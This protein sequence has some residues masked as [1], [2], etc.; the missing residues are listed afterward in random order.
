VRFSV[1]EGDNAQVSKNTLI[2]EF[3]IWNLPESIERHDITVKV[4]LDVSGT[5]FYIRTP[6]QEVRICL[7]QLTSCSCNVNLL[8]V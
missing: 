5:F 4:S 1:Y 2:G 6:A 8:Q 3:V 7:Q